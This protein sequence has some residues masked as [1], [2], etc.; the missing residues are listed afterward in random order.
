MS[1]QDF[2]AKRHAALQDTFNKCS[3][4][5]MLDFYA[6]EG[7]DYSDYGNL[8]LHMDHA[9]LRTFFLNMIK[10]CGD[11]TITT[12]SISGTKDFTVWEWNIEFNSV[13]LMPDD[14]GTKQFAARV[15]D[16]RRV[17]MVGVSVSWWNAEEKIVKNNDYSK[18][19]ESFEGRR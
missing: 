17:K 9:K 13:G 4:E 11:M 15:A 18:V 10:T 19:V 16:G 1:V 6:Q 2:I 5:E 12:V 8:T 14:D 3:L 7:L